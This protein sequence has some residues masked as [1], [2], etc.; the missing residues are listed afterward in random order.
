M[1]S[2]RPTHKALF[3]TLYHKTSH[4][5]PSVSERLL[6]CCTCVR[7]DNSVNPK[8]RL[9]ALWVIKRLLHTELFS[10]WSLVCILECLV[11]ASFCIKGIPHA[12]H[13]YS[14]SPVCVCTWLSKFG[15]FV[16]TFPHT[17]HMCT[18]PV[19][20]LECWFKSSLHLNIL[21][22]REQS[23]GRTSVCKVL[24]V[25]T[26][27]LNKLLVTNKTLVQFLTSVHLHV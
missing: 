21:P 24:F 10:G 18:S 1:P 14:F 19:C 27:F 16:K 17:Q 23:Y 15:C 11:K 2:H 4:K 25:K 22:H 9:S 6:T 26:P 3:T 5:V 12:W 7:F 8:W 20:N 13:K